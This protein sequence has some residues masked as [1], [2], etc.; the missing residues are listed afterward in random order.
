MDISQLRKQIDRIDEQILV[1]LTQRGQCA[2]RI[3]QLKNEGNLSISNPDREVEIVKRLAGLNK[4][5]LSIE[6][7]GKI[8]K[9]IIKVCRKLQIENNSRHTDIT[10][11]V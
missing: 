8:Y 3:G 1:L 4:G 9:S 7:I 10:E 6:D 11:C 5:P 2:L